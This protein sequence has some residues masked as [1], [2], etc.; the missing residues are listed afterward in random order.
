M[1]PRFSIEKLN[2]SH[3]VDDFDCGSE[4][5]NRFLIRHALANQQPHSATTYAGLADMAVIGFYIL[6][7]GHVEYHDAPERLTKGFA[8][9][10][11]PIMLLAAFSSEQKSARA[12]D[13][14]CPVERRDETNPAGRRYCW[15][16]SPCRSRKK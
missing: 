3:A 1:S 2:G 7:V 10:P 14:F 16:P 11:V 6:V 8:Q 12:R 15:Y 4:E 9:H 5:L 13:R